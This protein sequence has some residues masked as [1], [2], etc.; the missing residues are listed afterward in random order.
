[1]TLSPLCSLRS[2]WQDKKCKH[3][4]EDRARVLVLK[5]QEYA[6]TG[7]PE[8]GIVDP[9]MKQ[10]TVLTLDNEV[11]VEHGVFSEGEQTT[12]VLLS[13]FSV[14]VAAAFVAAAQ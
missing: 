4:V 7:T 13:G 3:S 10:I 2:L 11:Y 14:D 9:P 12:S 8:Y 6:Q 5:R 1:M